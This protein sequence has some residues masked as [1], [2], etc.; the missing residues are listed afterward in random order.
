MLLVQLFGRGST[1]HT[2]SSNKRRS[3]IAFDPAELQPKRAKPSASSHKRSHVQ[4]IADQ[5]IARIAPK[6]KRIKPA[7]VSA[8][9]ELT[10]CLPQKKKTGNVQPIQ[11]VSI[12]VRGK[13][14][15]QM[16]SRCVECGTKKVTMLSPGAHP[17]DTV[18]GGKLPGHPGFKAVAQSIAKRTG[19]PIQNANA[20]LAA[21]SRH[22]SP[23]AHRANPA[24]NRVRWGY[25]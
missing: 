8:V 11:I 24:L 12:Q 25:M 17:P 20:I 9:R 1:S 19:E 21:S 13:T 5:S 10:Y 3:H 4:A 15:W 22:A 2:M 16:K 18:H 14:R 23:A 6:A 7:Q